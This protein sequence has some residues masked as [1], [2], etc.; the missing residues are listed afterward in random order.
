MS[1]IYRSEFSAP[2]QEN[3]FSSDSHTSH[4][5]AQSVSSVYRLR[6][7]LKSNKWL[8]C[9][10]T[11]MCFFLR[12][13]FVA[14]VVWHVVL[15]ED[16]PMMHFLPF[17]PQSTTLPPLFFMVRMVFVGSSNPHFRINRWHSQVVK[18]NRSHR[19]SWAGVL[20]GYSRISNHDVIRCCFLQR[21][22]TNKSRTEITTFGKQVT[23]RPEIFSVRS[24][25]EDV[26]QVTKKLWFFS[27]KH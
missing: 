25:E 23:L 22:I 26:E 15:L 27:L 13:F 7:G 3:R 1:W 10:V 17:Y 6:S 14:F 12:H 24:C 11:W 2:Q 8:R 5:D 4:L 19:P 18:S 20:C 21:L 16:P 9:S